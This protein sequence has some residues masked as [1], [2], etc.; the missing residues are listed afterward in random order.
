MRTQTV[1]RVYAETLLRVAQKDD[2][3]DVVSDSLAAFVG[4]LK[5]NDTFRQF[6][7]APNVSEGDKRSL[8]AEV[9]SGVLHPLII[10]FLSLVVDKHRE[11]LIGEI[12]TAWSELIDERMN[13]QT[14]TVATAVPIDGEMVEEVRSS[15][16]TATGKSVVLTA[17][18]DPQLLGGLVI[19][20]G[21][22]VM[23][24]SLRTRLST[25]RQRLRTVRVGA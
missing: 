21:D 17:E 11:P 25:L 23:D 2:S 19:R 3:V 6:L 24:G 16:E 13:R 20:T 9:F 5:E 22:A 7:E 10:R 12:A 8:I 18:V 14:A 15:L 4:Y 1:S